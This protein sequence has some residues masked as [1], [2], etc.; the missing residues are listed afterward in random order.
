MENEDFYS[1]KKGLKKEL[2]ESEEIARIRHTFYSTILLYRWSV[3][4]KMYYF[5]IFTRNTVHYLNAKIS[6]IKI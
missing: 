6:I 3:F 4:I 1:E 5:T 2:S